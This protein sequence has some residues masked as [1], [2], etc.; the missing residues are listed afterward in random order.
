VLLAARWGYADPNGE[1]FT[2]TV[3]AISRE[4]RDGPFLW[5]T[6]AL[7][8]EEG[9]FL[10]CSFWLVDALARGGR[11]EEAR[12]LMEQLL[13]AANDVGLYAEEIDPATGAFLGNVP[14]ALTHLS[15][16][17]A[18]VSVMRAERSSRQTAQTS[19]VEHRACDAPARSGQSPARRS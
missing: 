12:K 4:L 7:K 5:R 19:S 13:A 14:Q 17:L 15:V 9:W 2:S 1:R 16:I 6:T 11:T 10:A 3:E 8:G 18:A